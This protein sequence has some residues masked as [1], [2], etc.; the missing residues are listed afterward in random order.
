MSLEQIESE[1]QLTVEN[2]GGIDHTEVRFEPGVTVL[3]GRNATNRTSLLQALMAGLGS[4]EVSIKADVDEANVELRF[5][6]ETYTRNLE[7]Q[8]EISQGHGDPFLDDATLADPFAFLLRSN[9]ARRA[10]VTEE[11]LR[12][13]LMR[14][15]DTDEI[16]AEIEHLVEERERVSDKPNELDNLKAKL[17]SLQQQRTQLQNEIEEKK[18]ELQEVEEEIEE[19]DANVQE[20][21][22]R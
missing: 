15:I 12:D 2:I 9:E 7:R 22:D 4:G 10:V 14:P 1:A 19:K 21:Q 16:H 11:N 3:V 5:G 6:E 8:K 13:V 18:D 20:G 17:P